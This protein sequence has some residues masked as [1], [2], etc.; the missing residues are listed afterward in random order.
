MNE[1]Q[2]QLMLTINLLSYLYNK[3]YLIKSKE[4]SEEFNL[5]PRSIRRIISD[6]R[7]IGYDIESVS[8]PHGGYR[9][10]RSNIILPVRLSDQEMLHWQTIE[11][12]VSSSDI[13]NKDEVLKTLSVI[14][15]Q[16]QLQ[17]S[18]TP[19]IYTTRI[20][21]PERQKHIDFVHKTLTDAMMLKQRVEIK[22]QGHKT[23]IEDVEWREFRPQQ[24]QI[25]NHIQYIKGYYNTES[26]SFR[27][28]RL[29]RFIDIRIINKKYSF[30]ENFEADNNNAPFS[31]N[32]Y[33]KYAVKLKIF[34]GPH[35]LLDYQYGDRQSVEEFE[36]YYIVNFDLEGDRIIINL[37]L[38][39]GINC[40]L[41][42]PQSIR[43]QIKKE[44]EILNN[45][46]KED[47]Q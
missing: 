43:D 21:L 19:D 28:L 42:E 33:K 1:Q 20:M 11:N 47:A 14:S 35:D 10:N 17:S 24:F 12:T 15:I 2:S 27:T 25:F 31:Q 44:Y 46:Y 39:L 32:V 18:Y 26:D 40:E 29:S 22:Y 38:S 6:L 5:S 23:K 8:G 41:L 30:N 13:N 4:L 45:I 16:S 7:D 3:N 37:V 9:L 34:K 36:D